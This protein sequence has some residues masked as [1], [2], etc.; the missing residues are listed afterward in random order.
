MN[1]K[2]NILKN[3]DFMEGLVF[4]IFSIAGI[5]F[6]LNEHTKMSI[7]WK[8]S[9]Y[10]FPLFISILLLILSLTLMLT[11][12]KKGVSSS[13]SSPVDWKKI[14]IF[15]VM[16]VIYY[17][18]IVY[19]GFMLTTLLFLAGMLVLMGEKRWW[20]IILISI[21]TTLVIWGLFAKFLHV[22]L[23]SGYILYYIG[24]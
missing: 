9:P 7:Q 17:N 10:L 19:L 8:L 1:N 12:W 11:A 4:F 23:P 20:L 5:L 2:N 24:L 21:L 18:V 6:S 14:I 22:L 13:K 16:C 15:S 3:S